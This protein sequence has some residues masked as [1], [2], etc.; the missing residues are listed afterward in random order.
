MSDIQQLNQSAFY[1]GKAARALHGYTAALL[2]EQ[3]VA[4]V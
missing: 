1:A 2:I 3:Q 4:L